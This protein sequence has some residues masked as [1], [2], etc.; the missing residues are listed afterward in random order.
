MGCIVAEKQAVI[1][2]ILKISQLYCL[3][4]DLT[5]EMSSGWTN[6]PQA[7]DKFYHEKKSYSILGKTFINCIF[8]NHSSIAFYVT[9]EMALYN[10][11]KCNMC[12]VY[13]GSTN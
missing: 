3:V 13:S 6:L 4:W 10:L 11:L 9:L 8:M 2:E 12:W 1:C 5:E 7:H